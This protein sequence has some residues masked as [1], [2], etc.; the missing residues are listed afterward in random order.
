MEPRVQYA[1][2]AD[3]IRVAY[4]QMGEGRTLVEMPPIP[5][6][7]IELEWRIPE[8][9][10]WY[11]RVGCGRNLVRY[12]SRRTGLSDHREDADFSVEAFVADLESVVHRLDVPTFALFA[13]FNAGPPAILYAAR[14]PERVSQRLWAV[15]A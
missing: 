12:D 2:T 6:S 11:E 8:I 7:H 1:I 3:G 15:R 4:W 10:A 9:R 5:Y 14:H 13:P